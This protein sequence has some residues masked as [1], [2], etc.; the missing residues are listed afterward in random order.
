MAVFFQRRNASEFTLKG[1]RV[2]QDGLC[3]WPLRR[4]FRKWEQLESIRIRPA[5][6]HDGL[7][8]V[9]FYFQKHR[10][11]IV[12][13]GPPFEG[14]F[15]VLDMALAYGPETVELAPEV[16]DLIERFKPRMGDA[17]SASLEELAAEAERYLAL[18]DNRNARK[19]L[20]IADKRGADFPAYHS[21]WTKLMLAK[22]VSYRRTLR[23]IQ[24]AHESFP[25]D[26][27]LRMLYYWHALTKRND[28]VASAAEDHWERTKEPPHLAGLL[29]NYWVDRGL[30]P[31]AVDILKSAILETEDPKATVALMQ[32]LEKVEK[33]QKSPARRFLRYFIRPLF[34]ERKLPHWFKYAFIVFCIAA[35]FGISHWIN[36]AQKEEERAREQKEIQRQEAIRL[37]PIRLKEKAEAGDVNAMV[38]LW[39]AYRYGTRQGFT[40]DAQLQLH[41]M[42]KAAEAGHG[43]SIRQLAF[44]YQ[45][46]EIVERNLATAFY[47]FSKGAEAGGAWS[48]WELAHYYYL[49]I[50]PVE[51]DF[52]GALYWY[53]QACKDER[54]Y[55]QM[56]VGWHYE[57]GLGIEKDLH[58]AYDFYRYASARGKWW[59]SERLSV[60]CYDPESPFYNPPGWVGLVYVGFESGK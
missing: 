22:R 51:Q 5:G 17:D 39:N 31:K 21:A 57:M 8:D 33:L 55:A 12:F 37:V 45:R 60:L 58:R 59:A 9:A 16:L 32:D 13:S 40:K 42:T 49:G 35:G 7:W 54:G 34:K 20:K 1:Y 26:Q 14:I 53:S 48:M 19:L 4:L 27:D 29:S 28:H 47:W 2:T 23:Y 50:E 56:Y 25:D 15:K 36:Q 30:Y 24:K 3:I 43:E 38:D 41:W 46:G 6:N 18:G 52:A 11:P 10:F 44:A